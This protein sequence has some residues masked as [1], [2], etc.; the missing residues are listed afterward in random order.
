MDDQGD[1]K[2]PPLDASSS[3]ADDVEIESYNEDL[4]SDGGMTPEDQIKK[5]REKLR[6]CEKE[7]LLNLDGWQR[8]K[9]DFVNFRKRQ[10]D[11]KAEFLKFANEG[12]IT[13]LLPVLESFQ[14][15]FANKEA[16]GK[17]DQA[18]RSGVEYIHTQLLQALRDH[19]LTEVDPIGKDFDPTEQMSVGIIPTEDKRL[20][21]KV[22]EVL[23]RGYRLGGKLIR[24]PQV[25]IYGEAKAAGATSETKRE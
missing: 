13:D 25:K 21:H 24:S 9:A 22:G 20:Y 7:K 10:E 14:M 1:S 4:G 18:W 3:E 8:T 12:V 2:K 15:A 5:L 16:W 17:V 19:G 23:Q 11:E 6:A